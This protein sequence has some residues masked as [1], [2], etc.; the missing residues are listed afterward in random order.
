[1]SKRAY[2]RG[3]TGIL[4]LPRASIR[5]KVL[6]L[7]VVVV[8]TALAS[9]LGLAIALFRQDKLAYVYDMNATLARSLAV[10]VEG[11]VGR[12]VGAL[13]KLGN[14]WERQASP[15]PAAQRP[16]VWAAIA[17][18]LLRDEQEVYAVEVW[19]RTAGGSFVRE[20]ARVDG[21]RL[22][23]ASFSRQELAKAQ[24]SV[25]IPWRAALVEGA[26]IGNA[27]L[28]PDSVI[29]YL[30]VPSASGASVTVAWLGP[31]RILRRFAGGELATAFLVDREGRVLAHADPQQVVQRASMLGLPI[32]RDALEQVPRLGVRAFE[33][34]DKQAFIGAFSRLDVPQAAVITAVP[35][36]EAFAASHELVKK[37]VRFAVGVILLG[38]LCSI[39]FSRRITAP[40]RQL[41]V[42]TRSLSRGDFE[43]R[44]AV[45]SR[46]EVGDLAR[47]FNQMAAE[48]LDRERRLEEARAQLLHSERLAVLG[49][50]AAGIS[51]EV[52]NP[53]AGMRGFAQLGLQAG[54]LDEA[55]EY[56]GLIEKETTRA[57]SILEGL[58]RFS[59]K[60]PVVHER[61][62]LGAVVSEVARLVKHQMQIKGIRV[63]LELG[64]GVPAVLGNPDQLQQVILNLVI[65]AQHAMEAQGGGE[66]RVSTSA[67][68]RC[69][70]ITVRDTGSGM[71]DEVQKNL[72]RAFHTTKRD[73]TGLGL[74][75]SH[76]IIHEHGGSIEVESAPGAGSTFRL[77][78]PEAPL[79]AEPAAAAMMGAVHE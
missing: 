64:E 53:M 34:P 73:G 69:A 74:S 76:R 75:V 20:A 35:T 63:H 58:L 79:V 66:L 2:W 10:E 55:Q 12:L 52:K 24:K 50:M 1:M 68:D 77:V 29:L 17:T 39:F 46:D 32:V 5:L 38:V 54:T 31:S 62:E 16:Q 67:G 43:T 37:S 8:V 9:Y 30:A 71:T 44:V 7:V 49:E 59:K 41:S 40:L 33:A 51:H 18:E 11:T 25:T 28:P 72:F 19:R 36:A 13:Q 3:W 47:A 21:T 48:L 15:R 6:A 14:D 57:T 42:A 26:V 22:A 23:D 56:F 45:T 78:L 70:V 65:N 4:R 60:S 27:S 61:L